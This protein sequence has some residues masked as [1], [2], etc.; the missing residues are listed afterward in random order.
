MPCGV[1]V[2]LPGSEPH[3][4][5]HAVGVVP[6]RVPLEVVAGVDPNLMPIG[7]NHDELRLPI[8]QR[9]GASSDPIKR[10]CTGGPEVVVAFQ[11]NDPGNGVEEPLGQLP[12]L[13]PRD[14]LLGVQVLQLPGPVIRYIPH[15]DRVDMIGAGEIHMLLE[16]GPVGAWVVKM[17]VAPE[18]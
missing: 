18:P 10:I 17:W 5:H 15:A 9:R 7:R 13:R 11:Q 4:P 6:H 2:S 16:Q 1:D 8:R 12:G 3:L 14:L